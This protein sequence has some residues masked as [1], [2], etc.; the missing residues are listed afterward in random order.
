MCSLRIVCIVCTRLAT[1]EWKYVLR[2]EWD[3]WMYVYC[4]TKKNDSCLCRFIYYK[5]Q[6][7][8][9][10]GCCCFYARC[11]LRF[12][13]NEFNRLAAGTASYRIRCDRFHMHLSLF[14]YININRQYAITS[15]WLYSKIL[16]WNNLK[17]QLYCEFRFFYHLKF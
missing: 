17:V 15:N 8:Y 3:D 2:L 1:A 9:F 11:S 7:L 6:M 16:C 5:A 10:C 12:L 14:H 4:T 13:F